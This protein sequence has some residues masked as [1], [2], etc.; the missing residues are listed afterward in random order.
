MIEHNLIR[1]KGI[2]ILRPKGPLT[3]GDFAAVAKAVDPYLAAEG[4]LRGILLE[5]AAFPGW[6]DVAA[7]LAHVRFIRGHHRRI[8]RIAAVTDSDFLAAMPRIVTRFVGP[9]IRHFPSSQRE[10]A[11]QWLQ[12]APSSGILMTASPDPRVIVAEASGKVTRGD[13]EALVRT[14]EGWMV[15]TGAT[16]FLVDLRHAEGAEWSAFWADAKFELRHLREIRRIAFIGN[17]HWLWTIP[18]L[19]HRM[20]PI[21]VRTFREGWE[22]D[23]WSWLMEA[24][25][26]ERPR[27]V[28]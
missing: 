27:R 10:A 6:S 16:C 13:V 25:S 17:Q 24:G 21:E 11:L 5:A 12:S 23:A 4:P 1:D 3:A 9:D 19:A 15:H 26:S 7:F 20:S 22:G 14:L 2:L 18:W 8:R 28:A